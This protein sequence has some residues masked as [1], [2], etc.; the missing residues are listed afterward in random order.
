MLM[1]KR[2]FAQMF[3]LLP[4]ISGTAQGVTFVEAIYH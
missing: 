1:L 3:V 2:D 4:T